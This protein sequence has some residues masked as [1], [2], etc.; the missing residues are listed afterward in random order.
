MSERAFMG[1]RVHVFHV[2]ML[3]GP[4]RL[5]HWHVECHVPGQVSE[6]L[7]E[8]AWKA[9]VR[10]GVPWVRIPPCPFPMR[11]VAQLG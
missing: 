2:W 1:Q 5:R 10:F 7:K 11:A 8:H 4:F 6:W 9:C 3:H